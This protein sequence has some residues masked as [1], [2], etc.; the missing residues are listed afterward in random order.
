MVANDSFCLGEGE[1]G[2][3][4]SLGLFGGVLSVAA[5]GLVLFAKTLA[6]LGAV[7]AIRESSVIFAALIG[8]VLFHERPWKLRVPSA[9][10]VGAG[11]VALAVG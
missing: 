6:P 4:L 2:A 5:Y 8:V 1:V 9:A 3:N 10:V 11:V 7:S